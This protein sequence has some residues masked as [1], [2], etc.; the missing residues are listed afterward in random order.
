[1]PLIVD[2][3]AIKLDIMLAFQRLSKQRP[4]T[5]ISLREIAAEAGMSHSKILR[6]FSD[7]NSL[8]AACVHWAGGLMYAQMEIWFD[9][10]HLTA[11]PGKMDYL[12]AFF[13]HLQTAQPSNVSPQDVVMAC[14][15][16]AYSD[17]LRSAAAEEFSRMDSL[18]CDRISKEFGK[19]LSCQEVQTI[20]IL[21]HGI[22]FS[23]FNGTISEKSAFRPAA[24][25]CSLL[26]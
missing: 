10:H 6:Y 12:D 17:E 7:K 1:M 18:F 11:Y 24:T 22:Y 23:R 20:S 15:L 2:K 3:E 9:T 25:I 14:A 26:E 4:M 19:I 8:L 21:F 16:S 5:A 13:L